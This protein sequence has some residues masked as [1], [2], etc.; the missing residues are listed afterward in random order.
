M[1]GWVPAVGQGQFSAGIILGVWP[2]TP[3]HVKLHHDPPSATGEISEQITELGHGDGF[4]V[5]AVVSR[6][7]DF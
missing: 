3:P 7:C 5:F 1:F 2:T 4:N 6:L